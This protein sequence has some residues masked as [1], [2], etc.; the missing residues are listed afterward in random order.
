MAS[1]GRGSN[2]LWT[3]LASMYPAASNVQPD[4]WEQHSHSWIA[5]ITG[6]K[7]SLKNVDAIISD[8]ARHVMLSSM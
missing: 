3:L 5:G 1:S 2:F 6:Y 7:E 4:G 8:E